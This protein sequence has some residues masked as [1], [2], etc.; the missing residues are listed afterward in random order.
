MVKNEKK[1][2]KCLC[3]K[4]FGNKKDNYIRHTNK[5]NPC[6]AI[7]QNL[8]KNTQNLL[9]NTQNDLL[10]VEIKPI[11]TDIEIKEQKGGNI[12]FS[13]P[14]CNK[15][16]DRKYNC[17]RHIKNCKLNQNNTKL[18]QNET[19]E[20]KFDL[21]LK[22]NEELKNEIDKL[23]TKINKSKKQTNI[24]INQPNININHNNI[25]VN[26]DDLN[27]DDVDK[28]LFV[29]PILN[30]RLFGKAIILKM[31]EN[32]YINEN[33]PEYHNFIITDKN[34]GYVKVY[35]NG[36]WKTDNI[37]MINML[38]DGII[39]HSKN[40]LIELKEQY[41]NNNIAQNRLNTSEKYINLCDLE[42]LADLEDE[43]NDEGVNNINQIKRCKDFRDMVYKDTI[44]LFHDNKKI[45]IK[46]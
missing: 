9:K 28:K 30:T 2:Y 12:K 19:K 45:L 41:I 32:V 38:I 37:T 25:I 18:N 35:N 46:K 43:Q 20:D 26:F 23:K 8:L 17:N 1:N 39:Y 44:N 29:N 14:F 15:N 31:I 40:I 13:C 21:I 27:F 16:F 33:H 5:I 4:D 6:F 36:K 24:N 34:R 11:N 10:C 22:Q 3:G 7:A 42:H